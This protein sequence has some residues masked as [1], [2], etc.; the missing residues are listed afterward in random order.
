MPE[1]TAVRV[2][3]ED[4]ERLKE[5]SDATGRDMAEIIAEFIP[6]PA[7]LCPECEEPFAPEEID[8]SSVEEHG[9]FSTGVDNLVKGQRE[10]KS[11]ECPCCQGRLSPGDVGVEE[12]LRTR[13]TAEE[14]GVTD[15][16][17]EPEFSTEEA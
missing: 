11:F 9:M 13:P 1:T 6:E 12:N 8:P 5:I 10:V 17:T 4:Q 7:Y 16:K 3:K 14:L 2:Y 15:E